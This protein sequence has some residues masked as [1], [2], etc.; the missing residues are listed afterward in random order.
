MMRV[1]LGRL[2]A[3]G[4]LGQLGQI[5]GILP[6]ICLPEER[7]DGGPRYQ[8]QVSKCSSNISLLLHRLLRLQ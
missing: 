8:L 6:L 2:F 3:A 5:I 7:K 4:C 1:K